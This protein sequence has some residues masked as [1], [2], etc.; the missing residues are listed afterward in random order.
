MRRTLSS[1]ILAVF[2]VLLQLHV[3]MTAS[4]PAQESFLQCLSDHSQ[5]SLPISSVTYFPNNSSYTTVLQSYIRNL[6]FISST[7]PKPVFIV[8]PTHVSHIQ[9]SIICSKIH[10]LEVRIRSGGHDYDGLSYVSHNPF[11]I[12][13]LFKLRSIN[14]NIEDQ[15]AWVDSGATIDGA[16]DIV[17]QWQYV[18]DKMHEDLFIRVV[19]LPVNKKSHQTVKA[20]FVALF[21]GNAEN[22]IALMDQSF[23]ELGL[24]GKDCIEMSWIE[25][26][27]YWSN[28]AIGTSLDVLLVRQPDSEKFLKKKSDY[29]QEPISKTGLEGI[30]KKMMQL[31]KPALTFNPYG[32]KMSE[33]SE[34]ETPFPHRSGNIYKIQYSV[35]WK[36]EG[37][38]AAD[39]NLDRIRMIYDYM[40]PHVSKSPRGS[41]LNYRDTDLGTNSVG[42]VSYSEAS[43]W[44]TK[45]SLLKKPSIVIS[46]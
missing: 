5:S 1:A 33:I 39:Q 43:V 32:G 2:A 4:D 40:R 31:R 44:A 35:N 41:Y 37:V 3:S 28:Y 24:S 36:E 15:S 38:E 42:N 13:D 21:L 34:S 9:A 22:L 26:V 19:V 12:I 6:R 27:L 45:V 14:V 7:T 10:G 46:R 18:A 30:W 17:Y 25:S 29:V 23:P 16:T 8:T 20:K 11:I